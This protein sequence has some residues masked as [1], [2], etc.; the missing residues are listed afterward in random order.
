VTRWRDLTFA[1][2]PRL[3][4]ADARFM[5]LRFG[6]TAADNVN[7][8]AFAAYR[9]G[10]GVY[11]AGAYGSLTWRYSE[12]LAFTAHG[13][14]ERLTGRAAASPIVRQAGARDQFTAGLTA[15]YTFQL[16]Q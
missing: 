7:N 4:L 3:N 9:P 16:G 15:S 13:G 5:R 8:P 14:W 1:I 10:G 12:R 6:V 2:G 11:S